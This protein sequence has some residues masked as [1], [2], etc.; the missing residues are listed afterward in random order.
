MRILVVED[1]R[2]LAAALRQALEGRGYS[3]DLAYDGEEAL[4]YFG[5]NEFDLVLLD[6][7]LPKQDGLHVVRQL[8]A[9]RCRVP[10]LMLTAREDTESKVKGLDSGADDY[11]AKPFEL[12]ELLARIRALLRRGTG[13]RAAT[14]AAA[15]LEV[16]PAAMTVRRA[17]RALSLTT[18]EYQLLELLVRNKNRVLSRE[19]I[20]DRI[21]ASHFAGTV[22]IVDVYINYLRVKVDYGF[23][24]KLLHTV[25]GVGYALRTDPDE[26]E[27]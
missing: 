3:V 22:K 11:L 6:V 20:F 19:V 26:G 27:A 4:D 23:E 15:D 18:R 12:A 17:G 13:E 16:D 1:E 25:R 24:P 8:R 5:A 9:R 7:M 21:W 14:L 2:K 10:V